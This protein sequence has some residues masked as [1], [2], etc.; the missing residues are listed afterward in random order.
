MDLTVVCKN[1]LSSVFLTGGFLSLKLCL[2]LRTSHQMKYKLFLLLALK[3]ARNG[4]IVHL[5]DLI[6]HLTCSCASLLSPLNT[7]SV[8]QSL[9]LVINFS[10]FFFLNCL[11][12]H[13]NLLVKKSD[14]FPHTSGLGLITTCLHFEHFQ[15]VH[16]ICGNSLQR[17]EVA[18][19]PLPVVYS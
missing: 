11:K 8:C 19:P 17:Q 2:S 16:T 1:H 4:V 13:I 15:K 12:V 6:S 3:A 10:I 14:D 7:N 9:V 18:F 5:T